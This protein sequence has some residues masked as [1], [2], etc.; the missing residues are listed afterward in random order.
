[1]VVDEVSQAAEIVFE[2]VSS[3]SREERCEFL[4]NWFLDD[5]FP[6]IIAD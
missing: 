2:H 6:Q 3:L 1:M 5:T 4:H